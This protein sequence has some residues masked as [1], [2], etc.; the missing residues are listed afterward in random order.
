[1]SCLVLRLHGIEKKS[2]LGRL[3]TFLRT[4]VVL[5]FVSCFRAFVVSAGPL[6][7]GVEWVAG[8]LDKIRTLVDYFYPRFV[9]TIHM[10]YVYRNRIAS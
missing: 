8:W 1:M 6:W 3:L 5:S 4:F 10:K 2:T 9:Y 7:M